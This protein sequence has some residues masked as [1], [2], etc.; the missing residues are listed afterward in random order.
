MHKLSDCK[1]NNK[2][3]EGGGMAQENNCDMGMLQ[4]STAARGEKKQQQKEPRA[5]KGE[6]MFSN[7]QK[8]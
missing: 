2:E 5:V 4:N 6:L 1:K 3:L 7:A 8:F